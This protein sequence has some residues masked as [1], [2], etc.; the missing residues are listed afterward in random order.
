MTF[1]PIDLAAANALLKLGASPASPSSTS[2]H[3]PVYPAAPT[4]PD[5]MSDMSPVI[6]AKVN[7]PA[8]LP[9]PTVTYFS[10]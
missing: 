5:L 7:I 3:M 2:K 1:N 10:M 6:I 4:M 8:A 9:P